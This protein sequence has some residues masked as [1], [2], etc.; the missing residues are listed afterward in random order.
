MESVLDD[1]KAGL[2]NGYTWTLKWKFDLDDPADMELV[3]K[4]LGDRAMYVVATTHRT[5]KEWEG[6]KDFSVLIGANEGVGMWRDPDTGRVYVDN[7][8]LFFGPKVSESWALGYAKRHGQKS[9]VKI[10]GPTRSYKF[11]DVTP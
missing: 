5:L 9:I 4:S 8:V 10:D 7:V 6:P 3:Y 2:R 11:L 1:V